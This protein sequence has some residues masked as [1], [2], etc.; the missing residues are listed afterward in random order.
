MQTILLV[1]HDP[2]IRIAWGRVLRLNHYHVET[3]SDGHA[4]LVAANAVKPAVIVTDPEMPGM[5][6]IEFCRHIKLDRK[7]EGIPIVLASANE[8]PALCARVWDEYWQKP[9]PTEVILT[10]IRR[11]LAGPR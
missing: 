9:V 1:D 4:G 3:A 6:G 5:D 7:F 10:S 8:V 2:A 11:L